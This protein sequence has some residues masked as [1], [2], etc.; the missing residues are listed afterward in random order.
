M[1]ISPYLSEHPSSGTLHPYQL[2]EQQA[3]LEVTRITG[4]EESI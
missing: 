4:A 3:L 2:I 1:R